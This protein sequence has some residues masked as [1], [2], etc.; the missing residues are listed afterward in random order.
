MLS[1]LDVMCL[2]V[3]PGAATAILQPR[4][5]TAARTSIEGSRV[6]RWKTPGL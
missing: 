6:E 3:M 4:G 1:L 2:H 5:K